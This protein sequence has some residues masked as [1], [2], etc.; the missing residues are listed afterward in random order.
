MPRLSEKTRAQRR[1]HI[2]TSAWTCFSRGGFHTTSMDQVIAA[3]G[4]SARAVYRYFGSKDEIIY[5]TVDE[6]LSRVRGIFLALPDRD[7]SPTPAETLTLVVAELRSRTNN[8]DYDMTRI[9]LQTW[10]EALRDPVLQK[11][12][13]AQYLETLNHIAE[14]A[15]RWRDEGHI[16]PYSDTNA[17]AATLFSLMHGLIVMHHLVDDV[18]SDALRNG[19]SLLGAA[20]VGPYTLPATRSREASP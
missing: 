14:L 2:L 11:R 16:P 9:A 17:V 19:L 12:A 3:T 13:R 4:M 18:P 10:A 20:V 5:A 1:Q 15:R 7:P 6:G 8:P